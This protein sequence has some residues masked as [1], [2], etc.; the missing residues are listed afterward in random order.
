MRDRLARHLRRFARDEGGAVTV[1]AV[2]WL[3]FFLGL[4]LLITNV[5][6]SFYAKAQA[7]RIIESANRAYALDRF[8]TTRQTRD[9]I[10][11][12]LADISP[13][14]TVTTTTANGLVS[15]TVVM[16]S[17]DLFLLDFGDYFDPFNVTV[18]AQQYVE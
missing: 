9:W 10:R 16:P 5:S 15:S 11:L 17:S 18:R 13:R 8:T 12:R 14:A 2:L 3:P 1:E 4:L 7:Y 6:F